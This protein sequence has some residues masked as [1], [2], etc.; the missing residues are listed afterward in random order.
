MSLF[1]IVLVLCSAVTHAGWNLLAR[2]Q[3][4][5]AAFFLRM[6]I[7]IVGIGLIPAVAGAVMTDALPMRAWLYLVGSGVC[8]GVYTFA[9]ARSYEL[10]DFTIVYPVARALPVLLIGFGDV[11]LGREISAVGWGGLL[12]VAAGA[13]FVPL[14]SFRE[15]SLKRY[16]TP[17]M[18]WMVMAASGT[19]GYSLF[20]KAA[21]EVVR[22]GPG[23]A[24]I[25]GYMFF[26]SSGVFYVL[27]L[28]VFARG[29]FKEDSI[30]W[31][32]PLLG[33]GLNFCGYWLVLWAFQLS[34]QASYV[35]AFRQVSILIGV[36]LAFMIYKE[37]G[38]VVR[39]VGAGLI[40]CGLVL[41]GVLGC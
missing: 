20:D 5:E 8:C 21:S 36:V 18:L 4:S 26:L 1:P 17:A 37:R 30:G 33:G 11:L 6:N 31:K 39:L 23:A 40:T 12:M 22:S 41:I 27:L 15:F 38:L 16:L 34:R 19:V 7:C 3:R 32:G 29:A 14:H 13:I 9:L 28:F 2:R 24:A 35:V 10:S 25:Y